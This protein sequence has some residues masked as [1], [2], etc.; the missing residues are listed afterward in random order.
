MNQLININDNDQSINKSIL[1]NNTAHCGGQHFIT[2]L[3]TV[4]GQHLITTLLTV[5]GSTFYN[6][7]AHCGGQHFSHM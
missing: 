4:G 7:T 5:G 2:T 6:N 1:N 3:L